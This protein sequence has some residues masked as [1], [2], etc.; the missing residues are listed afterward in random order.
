MGKRITSLKELDSLTPPELKKRFRGLARSHVKKWPE[1][2]FEKVVI[3]E[4]LVLAVREVAADFIKNPTLNGQPAELDDYLGAKLGYKLREVD[5]RQRPQ[6]YDEDDNYLGAEGEMLEGL[7]RDPGGD[8]SRDYSTRGDGGDLHDE[9]WTRSITERHRKKPRE[10]IHD[11]TPWEAIRNIRL[12]AGEQKSF[13]WYLDKA[14]SEFK[15]QLRYSL[16]GF[17]ASSLP[18]PIRLIK[19]TWENNGEQL[20]GRD[21]GRALWMTPKAAT[22]AAQAA[23]NLIGPLLE[24]GAIEPPA[25]K[26]RRFNFRRHL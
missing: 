21:A 4:N 11:P 13:P 1:E 25:P 20:S 7:T 14:T 24:I 26:Y 17:T 15:Y 9:K 19:W 10:D 23:A 22:A 12:E 8:E 6:M 16:P 18:G 5:R 2:V 3:E